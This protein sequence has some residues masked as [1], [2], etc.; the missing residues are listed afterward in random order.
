MRS[1]ICGCV[2]LT[3]LCAAIASCHVP[4]T[5]L[6]LRTFPKVSD[7][8]FAVMREEA[9]R[10]VREGQVL[11]TRYPGERYFEVS[12]DGKPVVLVDNSLEQFV[13]VLF[14][15]RWTDVPCVVPLISHWSA[16]IVAE[17][18]RA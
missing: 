18:A 5:G 13:I 15:D 1:V 4:K 3:A 6:Q 2:L 17:R 8:E 7:A 16:R 14:A 9:V 10:L 12:C 11:D